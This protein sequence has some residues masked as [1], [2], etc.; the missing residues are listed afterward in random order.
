MSTDEAEGILTGL[1]GKPGSNPAVCEAV[2]AALEAM[3][4]QKPVQPSVVTTGGPYGDEG[5]IYYCGQCYTAIGA[6]FSY[7]PYCGQHIDTGGR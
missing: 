7:C 6:N 5:S 3:D 2:K 1:V 4:R